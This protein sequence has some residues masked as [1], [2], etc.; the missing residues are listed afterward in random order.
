MF[1]TFG[2]YNNITRWAKREVILGKYIIDYARINTRHRR[3]FM[4]ACIYLHAI[5]SSMS[6]EF[7]SHMDCGWIENHGTFYRNI[8]T[9]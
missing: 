8:T 5:T 4:F 9:I 1:R 2:T 6:H 3:E 7:S